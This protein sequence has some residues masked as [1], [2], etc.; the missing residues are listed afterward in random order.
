[1]AQ[2]SNQLHHQQ[3]GPTALATMDL[4]NCLDGILDRSRCKCPSPSTM[5][6]DSPSKVSRLVGIAAFEDPGTQV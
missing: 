5:E 4:E 1:M 2:T 6:V 3:K